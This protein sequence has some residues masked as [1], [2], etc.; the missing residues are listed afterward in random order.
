MVGRVEMAAEE[1][2]SRDEVSWGVL[3]ERQVTGN[4]V[5]QREKDE[6]SCV[7]AVRG[8]VCCWQRVKCMSGD[9]RYV[10]QDVQC[11]RRYFDK[12]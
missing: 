8:H 7:E 5:K 11:K 12:R 3:G 6:E 1:Q 2:H 10:R 4:G 9:M